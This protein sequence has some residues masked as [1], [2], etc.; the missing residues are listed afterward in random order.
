ML[1]NMAVSILDK[2]RIETTVEKAKEVRR[3]VERLITFA[4]KG[5]LHSRRIAAKRVNDETVLK[6]L[7]DVIGPSFKTGDNK[8]EGGYTRVIKTRNRKGDNAVMAIVELVGIGGAE[9]VRK[10][11]KKKAAETA[12]GAAKT[13]PAAEAKA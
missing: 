1:S 7:F 5:D 12:P 10:R 8:R 6:K 4:K 2:E 11:R 3:V 13:A 9:T